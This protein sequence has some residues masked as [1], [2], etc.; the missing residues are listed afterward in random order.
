MA[1]EPQK[2]QHLSAL[3]GHTNG[4]TKPAS[5]AAVAGVRSG[6]AGSGAA[7]GGAT[8]KKLVIKNFRERPTL[9]DNYTQDT[10]QKLHE[11]VRA[12]QSSTSIKYN[13]EELYQAVE[14]VCSYKASPMLYKQLRQVCEDHVKAQILQFREYPFYIQKTQLNSY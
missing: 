2:K 1:G 10:W 4:F 14:N 11:A 5:L 3:V 9:P 8:S 7:A 12:I 13:L 6:P